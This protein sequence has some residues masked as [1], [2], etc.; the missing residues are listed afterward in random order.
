VKF[1][2]IFQRRPRLRT[3]D[4]MEKKMK[5]YKSCVKKGIDEE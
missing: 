2:K 5:K 1:L 4:Q 3:I